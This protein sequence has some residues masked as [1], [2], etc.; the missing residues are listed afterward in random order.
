MADQAR[1]YRNIPKC[2]MIWEI[3]EAAGKERKNSDR[4]TLLQHY[5]C[6]ALTDV[7]RG[8]Y[9]KRVQFDLPKGEAPSYSATD[10]SPPSNLMRRNI[11]FK[12]FVKGMPDCRALGQIK[13][14]KL[15]VQL[16]E[17]VHIKD[18]QLLVS[19]INKEK[20]PNLTSKTILEAFPGL[21]E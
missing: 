5:K 8:F 16:L 3:L 21:Y 9:D 15:F 19:M 2:T 14:E 13:K 10:E 20:I 12:Y 1:Q 7:L 6:A 11:M 17:S 4:I 18:S